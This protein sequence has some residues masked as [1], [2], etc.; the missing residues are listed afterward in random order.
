M[1]INRVRY[2]LDMKKICV[3]IYDRPWHDIVYSISHSDSL[4]HCVVLVPDYQKDKFISAHDERY[5]QQDHN[6]LL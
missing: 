1:E 3:K 4:Q 2:N 5:E 6:V